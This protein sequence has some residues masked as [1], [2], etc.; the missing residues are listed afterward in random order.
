MIE[1][2]YVAALLTHGRDTS[3]Q[4]GK[5]GIFIAPVRNIVVKNLGRPFFISLV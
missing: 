4:R 5:F 3:G 2:Q 1:T